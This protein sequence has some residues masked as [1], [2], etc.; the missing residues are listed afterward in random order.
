MSSIIIWIHSAVNISDKI[1]N[2]KNC[3][4]LKYKNVLFVCL[5]RGT[6]EFY[7]KKGFNIISLDDTFDQF[8]DTNFLEYPDFS[9]QDININILNNIF[10]LGSYKKSFLSKKYRNLFKDQYSEFILLLNYWNTIISKYKIKNSLILNGTSLASFALAFASSQRELKIVFWENGLLPNSLFLNING[11]NAFS[12]DYKFNQI[13]EINNFNIY[14]FKKKFITLL[15][16][17]NKILITLQVDHDSNIKLFSQFFSAVDL[18]TYID[19]LFSDQFHDLDIRFVVRKHPKSVINLNKFIKNRKKFSIST[20]KYFFDDLKNSDLVIT[21]NSTTGLEAILS[22][23]PLICFGNSFYSKF[24]R[25]YNINYNNNNL[26]IFIYDPD[27]DDLE[28]NVSSMFNY[29]SKCSIDK[30]SNNKENLKK[31]ESQFSS[32]SHNKY[33]LYDKKNYENISLK[34]ISFYKHNKDLIGYKLIPFL[35]RFKRGITNF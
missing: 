30:S 13:K 1:Y 27:D 19:Q 18:L 21:I 4:D 7:R 17:K 2:L 3:L 15:K 24:L 14:D 29:L 6:L 28:K 10:L 5:D 33:F 8:T 34:K 9:S 12:K 32:T 22:K 20:N 11:V 35:R 23:K 26:K 25:K 16:G 31:I